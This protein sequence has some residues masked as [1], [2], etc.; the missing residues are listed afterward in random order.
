MRIEMPLTTIVE[1]LKSD[2]EVESYGDIVALGGVVTAESV[3]SAYARGI[4]PMTVGIATAAQSGDGGQGGVE[5]ADDADAGGHADT[6]MP[7]VLAWWSPIE[8]GILPL[9]RLRISRSLAKSCRRYH[10]TV[11]ES[12]DE[13]L[14]ACADPNREGTWIQPDFH[15]AY[16]EMFQ[17]GYAHSFETRDSSGRLVG[18]LIC[19]EQGGLINGDSMFH[20]ERDASKVALVALVRRLRS[21]QPVTAIHDNAGGRLLDVQWVTEHLA[22]LGAVSVPRSSYMSMLEHARGAAPVLTSSIA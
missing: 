17:S 5:D 4:F 9:H 8:R 10:V 11:D 20:R 16:L 1:D 21:A 18:G 6:E 19:V 7:E 12:F 3:L 13:V 2:V 22:S 14:D 15:A